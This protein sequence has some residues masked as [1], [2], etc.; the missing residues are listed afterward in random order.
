MWKKQN[1]YICNG[2]RF[3][4]TEEGNLLCPLCKGD[5]CIWTKDGDP[6]PVSGKLIRG[7]M[8]LLNYNN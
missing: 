3:L 1:C 5:S 2:N 7:I 4:K 6:P 8:K